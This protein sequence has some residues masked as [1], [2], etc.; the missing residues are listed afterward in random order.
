MQ[1]FLQ[2]LFETDIFYIEM[3]SEKNFVEM[4]I[5]EEAVE[6]QHRLVPHVAEADV[7]APAV[8]IWR[9][10]EPASSAAAIPRGGTWLSFSACSSCER[11]HRLC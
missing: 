2:K 5:D 3:D 10:E 4:P 6:V 8:L 11:A 1:P 9:L 7:A